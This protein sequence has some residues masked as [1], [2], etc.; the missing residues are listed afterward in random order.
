MKKK[1]VICLVAAIIFSAIVLYAVR[2]GET[3]Q[4]RSGIY[5]LEREGEKTM[6]PYLYLDPETNSA[7]LS[8]GM[9]MS[10]A[11]TGTLNCNGSRVLVETGTT[12]YIFRIQDENTLVLT[13]CTG[14]NPF[15]LPPEGKFLY[16]E[17][18]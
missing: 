10:Y 13:D 6:I 5:L 7:H 2:A 16:S 9:T 3:V 1:L 17:N 14:E 15:G 12:I 11:E 8:G 18:G 4:L